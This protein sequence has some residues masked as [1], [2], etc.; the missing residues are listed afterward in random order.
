MV[1][2]RLRQFPARI[3][4]TALFGKKEPASLKYAVWG[5]LSGMVAILAICAVTRMA[6]HCLLIAPMAASAVLLFGATE[7]P[8]AQPRNLVGGHL[9]SAGLAVAIVAILGSGSLALALAVGG[10]IL[11]MH[12]TRTTHPPAGA[13]AFLAVQG[14]A[15]PHFVMVPVLAGVLVLLLVALFTNNVVYHRRYP[16]HWL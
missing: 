9:I 6:G 16:R 5:F 7:S 10:A 8:L 3:R 13:T 1:R 14:H 15:E 2:R 12:L 4:G 11:L